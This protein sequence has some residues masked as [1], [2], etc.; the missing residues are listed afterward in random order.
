[1]FD[2]RERQVVFVQVQGRSTSG[3][4]HEHLWAYVVEARDGLIVY[5][6]AYY[7]PAEALRAAGLSEQRLGWRFAR[8]RLGSGNSLRRCQDDR[9]AAAGS[10]GSR[11][12]DTVG[13]FGSVWVILAFDGRGCANTDWPRCA[14]ADPADA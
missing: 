14:S 6:R 5:F 8:A 13:V 12:S 3:I 4:P 11:G 2:A 9:A 10:C 7:E 1:V